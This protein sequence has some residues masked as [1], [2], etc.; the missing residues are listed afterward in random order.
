MFA[1][2]HL[3]TSLLA[4]GAASCFVFFLCAKL[5]TDSPTWLSLCVSCREAARM[6][7]ESAAS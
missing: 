2:L 4:S 1:G 6:Q 3:D 7:S 5:E